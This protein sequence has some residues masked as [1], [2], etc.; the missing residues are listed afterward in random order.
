MSAFS[1][2][3][4]TFQVSKVNTTKYT[5]RG[6]LKSNLMGTMPNLFIDQLAKKIATA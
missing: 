4:R 1:F 5:P 3:I 6:G 2:L